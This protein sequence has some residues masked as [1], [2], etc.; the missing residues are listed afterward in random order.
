MAAFG[1][2]ANQPDLPFNST[3][4]ENLPAIRA[5]A[6]ALTTALLNLLDILL[7]VMLPRRAT[8]SE[9]AGSTPSRTACARTAP[10]CR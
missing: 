6:D 5:D 10:K 1:E 4:V 2:R 8:N 7:D 9:T 3:V